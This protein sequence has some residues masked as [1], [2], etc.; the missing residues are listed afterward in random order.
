MP[1]VTRSLCQMVALSEKCCRCCNSSCPS[2]LSVAP[3]H[4][5]MPHAFGLHHM[6][7]TQLKLLCKAFCLVPCRNSLLCMVCAGLR[8]P[9]LLLCVMRLGFHSTLLLH[10]AHLPLCTAQLLLSHGKLC[11]QLVS[12]SKLLLHQA[13]LCSARCSFIYDGKLLPQHFLRCILQL[14]LIRESCVAIMPC[15][16][17]DVVCITCCKRH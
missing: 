6:K 14:V 2:R 12:N 8:L 17:W 15:C 10:R 5:R 3:Q 13:H 16:N 1:A 9:G 7:N 4:P 11:I